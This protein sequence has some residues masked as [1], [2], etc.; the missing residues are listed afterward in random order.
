M[1]FNGPDVADAKK[2]TLDN[3]GVFQSPVLQ[4]GVY[5]DDSARDAAV[6]APAAGMIIFNTTNTKFQG[7]TGSAWVDLN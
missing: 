7:Y 1:L 6:T 2:A 5:A 3:V 4:P